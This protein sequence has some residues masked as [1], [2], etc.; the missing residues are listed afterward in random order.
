MTQ[1]QAKTLA[2]ENNCL[3]GEKHLWVKNT[4]KKTHKKFQ[5]KNNWKDS[6]TLKARHWKTGVPHLY[7]LW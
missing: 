5:H 6:L 1:K 7:G 2:D 4:K 3:M